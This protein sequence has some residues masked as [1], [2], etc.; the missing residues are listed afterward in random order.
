MFPVEEFP[1][2]ELVVWVERALFVDVLVLVDVVLLFDELEL[3]SIVLLFALLVLLDV[4]LLADDVALVEVLLLCVVVEAVPLVGV[5]SGL[6]RLEA[7]HPPKVMAMVAI[8][9]KE[10]PR[11]NMIFLLFE[12]V[13]PDQRTPTTF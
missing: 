13:A 4:G 12:E 6:L 9:N 5:M 8:A 7:R 2:E 3:A 10:M 11:C 1:L